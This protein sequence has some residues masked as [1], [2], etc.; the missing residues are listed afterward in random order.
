M[1][2]ELEKTGKNDGH[3]QRNKNARRS[4]FDAVKRG[5]PEERGKNTNMRVRLT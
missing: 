1:A 3:I 4:G 2:K 5:R